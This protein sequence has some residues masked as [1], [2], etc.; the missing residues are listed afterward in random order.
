MKT[1]LIVDDSITVR[2]VLRRI[3]EDLGFTCHESENGE[4][5][6]DTCRGD[7][8]DA[9]FLDW[10]MPVMNG[11]EFLQKLRM[12]AGGDKPKVIFCSTENSDAHIRRAI[13]GGANEYIMKPF[14]GSIVRSKLR[15]VG[16]LD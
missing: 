4:Q 9:I 10:N 2:K 14:D 5:A 16:L 6:Y 8:P 15:V 11:I 3:I 12:T 13:N 1:C 7:M